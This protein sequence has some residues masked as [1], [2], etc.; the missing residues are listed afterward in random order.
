MFVRS[1]MSRDVTY[2]KG[3][4]NWVLK[5]GTVTFVDEAKVSGK[6]L[7]SLYGSRIIIISKDAEEDKIA[8]PIIEKQKEKIGNKP[9]TTVLDETLIDD[10]I[11]QIEAEEKDKEGDENLGKDEP[12]EPTN[13]PIKLDNDKEELEKAKA[14]LAELEKKLEEV[15]SKKENKEVKKPSAKVNKTKGE[16]TKKTSQRRRKT[17]AK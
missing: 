8:E 11:A 2:R 1:L 17:K 5:A 10:I 9:V 15:I 13:D 3:G 16:T 14:D 12:L 7:K 4:I 6:E